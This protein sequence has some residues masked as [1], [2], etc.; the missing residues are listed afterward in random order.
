M[1]R[2]I[3]NPEYRT[4]FVA[5]DEDGNV[6]HVGYTDPG[7]YTTTGQEVF[8]T[9]DKITQMQDVAQFIGQPVAYNLEFDA[10]KRNWIFPEG[11][12]FYIPVDP[13]LIEGL[14]RGLYKLIDP[15]GEGL[16]AGIIWHPQ[17]TDA[18]W[19]VLQLRETDDIPISLG[20]DTEPLRE[21]LAEFVEGG[22]ITQ[23]ELDA[24]VSSVQ[25]FAGQTVFVKDFVP[26]SWK[27]HLMT[28]EQ[29]VA[30]GWIESL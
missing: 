27:P 1:S 14:S 23:E 17:G 7:S 18:A 24:I 19:P 8:I 12:H 21:T 20:A 9:G 26:D 3:N 28:K 22:G 16:Y 25:F 29:V 10:E 30:G 5:R 6:L 2:Q 4:Y 13:L 15:D 11:D